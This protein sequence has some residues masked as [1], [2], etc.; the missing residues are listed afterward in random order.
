MLVWLRDVRELTDEQ[1][2]V[3]L[4]FSQKGND[5]GVL[6]GTISIL[7]RNHAMVG[8]KS[9]PHDGTFFVN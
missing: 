7:A 2:S 9:V 8:Y 6:Q 1:L 3:F 5:V 4:R